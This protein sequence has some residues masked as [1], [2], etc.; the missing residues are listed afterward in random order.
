VYI[1]AKLPYKLC[2]T[3][4]NHCFEVMPEATDLYSLK[5][6]CNKRELSV[7]QSWMTF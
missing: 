7:L 5:F 3:Q 4:L 6:E 1:C 2:Y